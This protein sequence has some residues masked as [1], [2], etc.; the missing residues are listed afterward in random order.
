MK[1][2]N[3]NAADNTPSRRTFLHSVGLVAA[4]F[5]LNAV[6]CS[7]T[8]K[9]AH[10]PKTESIQGLAQVDAAEDVYKGWV[11]V[12]DRKVRV[13]VIGYGLCKFGAAFGFQNHP[14]VEI[15]AVSDLYKDRCEALA[16]ACNCNKMYPSLEELVKDDKVEAVFI[17]TDAAS[18]GKHTHEA[19]NH[20]QVRLT[21]LR[22]FPIE[23]V[24][25]IVAPLSGKVHFCG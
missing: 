25:V 1:K 8:K 24:K 9:T 22:Q 13:G 11:P 15:V 14:N 20:F 17:A 2:D 10:A 16:K 6:G 21:C 3:V 4:A 7:P 5:G 23:A 19:L 12:S 18:H